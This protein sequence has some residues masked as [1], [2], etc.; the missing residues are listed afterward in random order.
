[1][2]HVTIS[3][4]LPDNQLLTQLFTALEEESVNVDMISQIVNLEGLQLSF[5]L[6]IVM[7]IKFLQFWK[8]YHTLLST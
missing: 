4:P 7:H 6:K 3:Y 1:M 5:Q 8:I 2:M